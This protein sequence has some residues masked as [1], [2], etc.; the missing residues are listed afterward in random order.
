MTCDDFAKRRSQISACPTVGSC[1]HFPRR[2]YHQ[3]S[4]A[5]QS[6]RLYVRARAGRLGATWRALHRC[7]VYPGAAVHHFELAA[8]RGDRQRQYL[9]ARTLRV[10]SF[11]SSP[12]CCCRCSTGRKP[13][14]LRYACSMSRSVSPTFMSSQTAGKWETTRFSLLCLSAARH[15]H[16]MHPARLPG[17]DSPAVPRSGWQLRRNSISPSFVR[18]FSYISSSMTDPRAIPSPLRLAAADF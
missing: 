2:I 12:P 8:G 15:G 4:G 9:F 13:E 3:Q 11:L 18:A 1:R 6:K 10:Q 5:A 7:A 16:Q 17:A 14:T